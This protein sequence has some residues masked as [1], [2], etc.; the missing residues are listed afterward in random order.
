MRDTDN[1]TSHSRLTLTMPL[2]LKAH[3]IANQFRQQQSN[4]EKAKQ[5]YLNALAVQTVQ[6]YLSWL[7]I[8]T[9]LKAS[10]SWNPAIQVLA[11]TADLV[12]QGRGKLECR[13]VLPGAASCYV[14]SEVWSDRIGYVAV[15]F[16]QELSE[17][18]LLGFVPLVTVPELPLTQ[19]R[20]LDELLD[21]LHSAEQVSSPQ[22]PIAL[23]SWLQGPITAGWQTLEE[24]FGPQQPAWSFRNINQV[25]AV[26]LP[27]TGGKLLDLGKELN[28][29]PVALLVSVQPTAGTVMDIWVKICPTGNQTHLPT[30]L[31]V[32]VLDQDEL[33]VMQAQ[34]RNAEMIQL[35]FS[36][37]LGEKFSIKVILGAHSVTTAFVI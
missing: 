1:A 30:E 37:V 33:T 20:S 7:G 15:Q 28:D 10:D 5:V 32:Q 27:A 31:D 19:L 34:S 29:A 23:G 22:S 14:P 21:R 35:K 9:D 18:T 25:Q 12:V 36:G 6:S 26:E 4:P 8:D 16:D 11:D 17:A 24:L 13:P 3:H 2:T